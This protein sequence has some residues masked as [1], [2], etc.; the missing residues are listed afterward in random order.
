MPTPVDITRKHPRHYQAVAVW[1]CVHRQ[2]DETQREVQAGVKL[3]VFGYCF[4]SL[5]D[6]VTDNQEEETP[7]PKVCGEG[8][9]EV[10]FVDLGVDRPHHFK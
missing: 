3:Q 7:T 9:V 2:L 8:I 4:P 5:A 1:H 6:P 10:L